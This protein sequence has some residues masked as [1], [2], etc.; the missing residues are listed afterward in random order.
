[1]NPRELKKERE[2]IEKELK[3]AW[4]YGDLREGNFDNCINRIIYYEK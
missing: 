2:R 3:V 1:M 4:E